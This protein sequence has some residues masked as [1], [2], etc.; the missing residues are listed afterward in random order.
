MK[1]FR[2]FTLIEC[3]IAMAILGIA[4]LLLCQG[5]TALM[6]LTNRSSVMTASLGQQ[7]KEAESKGA[8]D[9]VPS[10]GSTRTFVIGVGKTKEGSLSSQKWTPNTSTG[11]KCDVTVYAVRGKKYQA[12][13]DGSNEFEY[14]NDK[15]VSKDGK[16]GSEY[17]Y[18]Y[19]K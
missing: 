15:M 13:G 2:A 17:R 4:S 9:T 11:Y 16:D 5:Y 6:R 14:D 19:F 1:K 8:V 3:L 7:M 10:D 12:N 18:A